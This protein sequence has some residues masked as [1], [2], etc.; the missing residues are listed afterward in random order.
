MG[1]KRYINTV[2]IN[3]VVDYYYDD[4][5]EDGGGMEWRAMGWDW[6]CFILSYLPHRAAKTYTDSLKSVETKLYRLEKPFA[7]SGTFPR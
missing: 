4:L 5:G 7:W 2:Y 1:E 6:P 3:T